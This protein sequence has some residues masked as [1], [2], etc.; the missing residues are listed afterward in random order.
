MNLKTR[1]IRHDFSM[2]LNAPNK[3]TNKQ[4]KNK[5]IYFQPR[6]NE[7]ENYLQN[8][9]KYMFTFTNYQF[10]NYS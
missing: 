7:I 6:S 3:Q 1:G 9:K 4:T 2:T 10:Q 8:A 5:I